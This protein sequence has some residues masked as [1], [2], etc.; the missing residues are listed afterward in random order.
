MVSGQRL[1]EIKPPQSFWGRVFFRSPKREPLRIE[2]LPCSSQVLKANAYFSR[3]FS[4]L[5]LSREIYS[6]LEAAVQEVLSMDKKT[7]LRLLC[8]IDETLRLSPFFLSR[9][10]EVSLEM[11]LEQKNDF[12]FDLLV[13]PRLRNLLISFQGPFKMTKN[14]LGILLKDSFSLEQQSRVRFF[15]ADLLRWQK[16]SFAFFQPVLMPGSELIGKRE[17]IQKTREVIINT[18]VDILLI[19]NGNAL[20]Y[21]IKALYASKLLMSEKLEISQA[22]F[23][24]LFFR[25]KYSSMQ[26]LTTEALEI[27]RQ[28]I[29]NLHPYENAFFMFSFGSSAYEIEIAKYYLA[30]MGQRGDNKDNIGIRDKKV[31]E[32]LVQY[33]YQY[34]QC[35][36]HNGLWFEVEKVLLSRMCY[37]ETREAVLEFIL[38]SRL[39]DEFTPYFFRLLECSGQDISEAAQHMKIMLEIAQKPIYPYERWEVN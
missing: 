33:L 18:M 12:F 9:I 17:S 7:G 20:Y 5:G 22:I 8:R 36:S 1:L 35:I 14:L 16:S 11:A 28:N 37:A 26:G 6:Q 25:I 27:V 24:A 38:A 31:D 19:S 39:M 30:L 10:A 4:L 32:C 13:E 34:H 2:K 29:A 3:S 21:Y 23:K 15:L